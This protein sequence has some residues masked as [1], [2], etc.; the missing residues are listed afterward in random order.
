MIV[1]AEGNVGIGTTAPNAPLAVIPSGAYTYGT[2][3]N[4]VTNYNAG[5]GVY[6]R[7]HDFTSVGNSTF[8]APTGLGSTVEILVVAGG[9]SGG[10]YFWS[11]GGA[12]GGVIANNSYS[13]TPGASYSVTVGNKGSGASGNNGVPGGNSVFNDQTAT[14]GGYGGG[15]NAN[16]GNGGS[17]YAR[18]VEFW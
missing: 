18:I 14:G 16:G 5:G 1:T 15:A 6:Y 13:I 3:G 2:G 11:G 12:A 4:S 7:I 8:V 9:G 10:A 17:G